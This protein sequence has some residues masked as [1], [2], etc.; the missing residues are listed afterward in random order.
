MN[1]HEWIGIGLIFAVVVTG[2]WALLWC[3]GSDYNPDD[4]DD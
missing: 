4:E 3:S 1:T 2:V